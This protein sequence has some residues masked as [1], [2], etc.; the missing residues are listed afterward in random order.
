MSKLP[1]QNYQILSV[2]PEKLKENPL[3]KGLYKESKD[4]LD[5]LEETI[6]TNGIITPLLVTD[7]FF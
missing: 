7:V 4:L 6:K 5:E 2:S 1:K 3:S